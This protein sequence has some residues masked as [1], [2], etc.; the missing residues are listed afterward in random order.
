MEHLTTLERPGLLR[1]TQPSDGVALVQ[2]D[3]AENKNALSHAMVDGLGEVYA[4]LGRDPDVR[5]IV[6]A[7]LPEIFPAAPVW[8]FLRTWL[9]GGERRAKSCF[10]ARFW[11]ARCLVFQ[12]WPDMA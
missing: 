9:P 8:R 2:M 1:V 6:L 10:P 3:D 7:G 11:T 12:R 5:A 4:R